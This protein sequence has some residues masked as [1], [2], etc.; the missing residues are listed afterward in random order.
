MHSFYSVHVEKEHI[1]L[2]RTESSHAVRVLRLTTGD[3]VKILDGH[4]TIYTGE[5][6][7]PDPGRVKIRIKEE[8]QKISRASY[9]LHIA[10]APTKSINRFEFFLEKAMESGVDEV[11]PLLCQHSERKRIRT[12]RLEKL[13]ITAMKQSLQPFLPH[14]NPVISFSS[15]IQRSFHGDRL[16]AHCCTHENK[17]ERHLFNAITSDH[18]LV[19]IGP[20]G[21]FS[22][23]EINAALKKGY[24][25]VSLGP[26]R[27]RTETAG[28]ATAIIASVRNAIEKG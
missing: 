21:D 26:A 12:D 25:P 18:I 8:E 19:L 1:L 9:Y 13:L 3:M 17:P 11:T 6:E 16:I 7:V 27:L 24:H 2:D 10:I 14:L 4:G 23:E 5:I 20:E 15:F 28:I 22:H